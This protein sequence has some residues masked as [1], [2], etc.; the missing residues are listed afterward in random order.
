MIFHHNIAAT[1]ASNAANLTFF[2]SKLDNV[3]YYTDPKNANELNRLALNVE[4]SMIF[5][6]Y[7]SRFNWSCNK[8]EIPVDYIEHMLFFNGMCAAFNHRDY[9]WMILP[10]TI[11]TVNMFGQPS[12]IT[13]SLPD[14]S[15]NLTLN[16][17]VLIKDNPSFTVPY[18]VVKYYSRMIADTGRT[19]DVY[20]RAMKKPL[21]VDGDFKSQSTAKQFY[22]SLSRNENF[23]VIDKKYFKD[24]DKINIIQNTA[25]KAEDLKGIQMYKAGLYNEC[26]ARLGITTPT[27][28]KQAQVNQDEINKNDAMTRVILDGSFKCRQKAI[29][30]IYEKSEGAINLKCDMSEEI[31]PDEKDDSDA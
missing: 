3:D 2:G 17:F 4:Q 13:V 18:G 16:D 9:G 11:K 21:I 23:I 7:C 5:Q 22:K 26:V 20:V 10:C 14:H 8:K 24:T 30:E 25:H 1:N 27:I 28:I 29:K 19:L 6:L 31:T 12:E 15:E